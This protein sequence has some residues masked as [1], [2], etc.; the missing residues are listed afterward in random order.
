ME[1]YLDKV[2]NEIFAPGLPSVWGKDPVRSWTPSAEFARR[3]GSTEPG[4]AVNDRALEV[5]RP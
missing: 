2:Y 3:Y 1:E 5:G 4:D